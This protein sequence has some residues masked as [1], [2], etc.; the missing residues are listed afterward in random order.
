MGRRLGAADSELDLLVDLAG[1]APRL[2]LRPYEVRVL[3][4][5]VCSA[6]PGQGRGVPQCADVSGE[7]QHC[8]IR[9]AHPWSLRIRFA[10]PA[11]PDSGEPLIGRRGEPRKRRESYA[12]SIGFVLPDPNLGIREA[13]THV[14]IETWW[15]VT[16]QRDRDGRSVDE[17]LRLV[18]LHRHGWRHWHGRPVGG[19]FRGV[20]TLGR[21][22]LCE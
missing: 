7:E 11:F 6:V 16:N 15:T 22:H 21:F 20:G 12:D 5:G 4:G 19:G 18:R 3:I 8:S 14:D 13:D 1:E 17:P 2:I 9:N 10:S